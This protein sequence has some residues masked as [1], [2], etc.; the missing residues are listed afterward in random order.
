VDF[1]VNLVLFPAVKKMKISLYLMMLSPR[2]WWHPFLQH[3]VH[4]VYDD[5][6]V[7]VLCCHV[8]TFAA[9]YFH[10]C[11]CECAV[12]FITAAVLLDEVSCCGSIA[13]DLYATVAV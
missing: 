9:M 11:D 8:I 13:A 10:V 2:V 4:D 1:I 3:G 5:W 7:H 6:R 12:L